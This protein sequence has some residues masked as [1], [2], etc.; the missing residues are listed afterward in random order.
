[1]KTFV[2]RH[3]KKIPENPNTP[4][5]KS[6]Q[7]GEGELLAAFVSDP[8][9]VIQKNSFTTQA[10]EDLSLHSK[11]SNEEFN[12]P[13]SLHNEFF[14]N[15]PKPLLP[16]LTKALAPLPWQLKRLVNAASNG[17]LNIQVTGVRDT[18]RFVMAHACDYLVTGA[19][20]PLR[21]LWEVYEQWQ[22]SRN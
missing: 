14:D 18:P 1:V 4:T 9:G 21:K 15:T 7:K 6:C 13:S 16:K 10:N 22:Q 8:L 12:T 2:P 20:E 5:D 3:S 19:D 11:N 17:V